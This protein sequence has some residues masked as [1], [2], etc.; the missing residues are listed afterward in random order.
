MQV[1]SGYATVS[2]VTG[3][4]YT[5]N[6]DGTSAA[7]PITSRERVNLAPGV[8]E[9]DLVLGYTIS[10]SNTAS[11]G[12]SYVRQFNAGGQAGLQSNGV[13]LMARSVF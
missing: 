6:N 10:R 7:N 9:M 13:A 3:Y 8:R 1:R 5:D 12:I 2:G 4:T 11:V